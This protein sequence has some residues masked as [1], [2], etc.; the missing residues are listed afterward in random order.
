MTKQDRVLNAGHSTC[1]IP[2]SFVIRSFVIPFHLIP[3][4]IQLG[5]I[6]ITKLFASRLQ[7]VL[8]SSEARDKLVRAVCSA[9]SASSLALRAKLTTANSKVADLILDRLSICEAIAALV[10][11]VCTSSIF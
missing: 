10:S 4:R 1:I 2:S 5:E 9:L 7:L 8:D 6:D 3:N 11:T